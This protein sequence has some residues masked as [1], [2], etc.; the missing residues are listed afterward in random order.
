MEW[1]AVLANLA[2]GGA[3]WHALY[4][5]RSGFEGGVL[6]SSVESSS[7]RRLEDAADGRP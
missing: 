1:T 4:P 6:K 2:S 7:V 3:S 5:P